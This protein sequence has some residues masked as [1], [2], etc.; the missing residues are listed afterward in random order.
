MHD[1][2][3]CALQTQDFLHDANFKAG[4]QR[5][6]NAGAVSSS[7]FL[8]IGAGVTSAFAV[9][10][11]VFGGSMHLHGGLPLMQISVE[12]GV[13]QESLP[14]SSQ[15]QNFLQVIYETG[16]GQRRKFGAVKDVDSSFAED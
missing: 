16:G 12:R 10:V 7:K 13:E 8:L 4:G 2:F 15:A 5:T 9:V 11:V 6:A 1:N 14:V 3:P